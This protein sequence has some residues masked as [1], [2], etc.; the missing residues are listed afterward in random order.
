MDAK[1]E[2]RRRT[3]GRGRGRSCLTV[4]LSDELIRRIKHAAVDD[5][6]PHSELVEEILQKGMRRRRGGSNAADE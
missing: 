1:N 6:V 2:L 4:Y 3:D 5:G